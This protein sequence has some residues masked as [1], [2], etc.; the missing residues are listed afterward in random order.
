MA[1]G[2]RKKGM[3]KHI[4]AVERGRE[5]RRQMRRVIGEYLKT[6]NWDLLSQVKMRGKGR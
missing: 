4:R 3:R 6:G 5:K 1:R 2:R